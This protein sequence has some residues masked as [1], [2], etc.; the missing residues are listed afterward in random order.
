MAEELSVHSRGLE[1]EIPKSYSSSSR[2][3]IV[4]LAVR[5][6][7]LNSASGGHGAG[8]SGCV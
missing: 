6:A 4:S 7:P 5:D 8:N 3:K 2:A 1:Q